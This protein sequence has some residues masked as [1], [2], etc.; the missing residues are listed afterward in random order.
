MALLPLYGNDLSTIY[1]SPYSVLEQSTQGVFIP[2][3][4]DYVTN[5]GITAGVMF[6]QYF[7]IKFVLERRS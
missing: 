1:S 2:D 3:N 7:T 5:S 6:L 4:H